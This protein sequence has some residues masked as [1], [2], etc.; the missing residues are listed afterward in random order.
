MKGYKIDVCRFKCEDNY[1][2]NPRRHCTFETYSFSKH[3][4][5]L[6]KKKN[7]YF[8]VFGRKS[9]AIIRGNIY[10]CVF[11][12]HIKI[13]VNLQ[14]TF[15]TGNEIMSSWLI[16]IKINKNYIIIQLV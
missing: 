6:K 2:F 16:Y 14:P 12:V 1:E 11:E 8:P 7:I 3:K 10:Y 13:M 15:V 9:T 4:L 5:I